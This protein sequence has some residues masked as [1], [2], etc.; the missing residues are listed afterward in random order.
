MLLSH[1]AEQRK[2]RR[3][4]EALRAVMQYKARL[5]GELF[6]PVPEGSRREF[7]CL[8]PHTWV[9]HEEW[10]DPQTGKQQVITTRYDIRPNGIVKSQGVNAYQAL[11]ASEERH[12]RQAVDLYDI[13]VVGAMRRLAAQ[14]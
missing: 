6:G 10:I 9:W 14:Y 3:K 13:H 11:S 5:G 1:I 8:D 2:Q 4:A 7:F 12:F